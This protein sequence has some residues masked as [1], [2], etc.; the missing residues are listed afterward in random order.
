MKCQLKKNSVESESGVGIYLGP[1]TN[2][3]LVVCESPADTVLNL[4]TNNELVDCQK[5]P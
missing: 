2:G 3:C 1:G 5:N 4:G